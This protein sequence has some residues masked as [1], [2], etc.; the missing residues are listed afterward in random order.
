MKKKF[1]IKYTMATSLSLPNILNGT[2]KKYTTNTKIS[3][4]EVIGLGPNSKLLKQYKESLEKLSK[5]QWEAA[6]GL[7][8]GDASLQTQN[9]GKTYRMKF[10]WGNKHK[11]YFGYAGDLFDE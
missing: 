11:V 5:V 7:I 3:K 6:I 9:K 8:L 2:M 4:H 10:E 1:K